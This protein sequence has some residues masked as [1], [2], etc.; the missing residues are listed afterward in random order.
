MLYQIKGN[1]QIIS[2][3]R[4]DKKSTILFNAL[5]NLTINSDSSKPEFEWSK[6]LYIKL[7]GVFLCLNLLNVEL[8]NRPFVNFNLP[9]KS[10]PLTEFEN[11][12]IRNSLE[13]VFISLRSC[14]DILTLLLSIK[15]KDL[16]QIPDSQGKKFPGFNRS[17]KKST[18][19]LL[20]KNN[21]NIFKVF[22]EYEKT[23]DEVCEYR[24]EIIH[25]RGY[26]NGIGFWIK[27]DDTSWI[28]KDDTS[29]IMPTMP[30][31]QPIEVYLDKLE[32]EILKFFRKILVEFDMMP[33]NTKAA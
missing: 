23:I 9:F 5:A 32:S 11:D 21:Q 17:K 24:D 8:K 2:D 26:M 10:F 1:K 19:K 30:D 20:E 25:K 16:P 4:S 7:H 33:Y 14:L 15:V 6:S 27:R 29:W 12:I 13:S 28:K 18:L 3:W 31:G 22:K